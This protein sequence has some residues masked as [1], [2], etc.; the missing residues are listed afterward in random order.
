MA[1]SARP[2]PVFPEVPSTIVPPVLSNPD[3]S[4]SSII[5]TAIRSLT[6]LPGLKLSTFANTKASISLV[7]V[8]NLTSGVFPMVSKIVEAYFMKII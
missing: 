2:I 7:M 4:A 8:F 3:A 1:A 6:E 5:L